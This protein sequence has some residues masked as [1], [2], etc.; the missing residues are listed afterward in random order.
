MAH[1]G[2]VELVVVGGA[3]LPDVPCQAANPNYI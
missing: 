3:G 2:P 1:G